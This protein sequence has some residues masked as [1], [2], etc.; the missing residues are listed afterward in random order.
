MDAERQKAV[1]AYAAAVLDG[2]VPLGGAT[3]T[4]SWK[5]VTSCKRNPAG[6]LIVVSAGSGKAYPLKDPCQF[7]GYSIFSDTNSTS[8]TKSADQ[9][10]PENSS[11]SALSSVVLLH[12]GL[13]I[14]ININSSD[15]INGQAHPAGWQDVVMESAVTAIC[16]CE[17]SVAA[18]DAEDK[19]VVCTCC[20]VL[21]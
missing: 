8:S 11:G 5:N 4:L 15:P 20:A 14:I 21:P 2:A 12:N 16:D 1:F 3:S 18:V 13:H 7:V 9:A 17:D 6:D 19:A 10:S